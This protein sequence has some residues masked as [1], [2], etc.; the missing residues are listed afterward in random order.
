MVDVPGTTRQIRSLVGETGEVRVSIE[1]V[2]TPQPRSHQVLVR[3][4]AA[5]LN[6]SDLGL[7]LAMSDIDN[8]TAGG[9]PDE[10]VVSGTDLRQGDAES[11][12]SRRDL[13][14]G[15]QR[16]IRCRRGSR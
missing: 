5:P 11:Q 13:H 14:A 8:A 6:P 7:L 4:E 9:S 15:R 3:V 2:E 16:G 12:G 1:T 10:P